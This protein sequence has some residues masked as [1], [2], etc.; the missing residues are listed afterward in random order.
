MI[1]AGSLSS[2]DRDVQIGS[3]DG[4]VGFGTC[5][6]L[7]LCFFDRYIFPLQHSLIL[8]WHWRVTRLLKLAI[9][10]AGLPIW[11][12]SLHADAVKNCGCYFGSM[13]SA[14]FLVA[15]GLSLLDPTPT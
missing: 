10:K 11:S 1:D 15:W 3:D 14:L 5:N 7:E 2:H 13:P 9:T 4:H 6:A 12:R 8:T